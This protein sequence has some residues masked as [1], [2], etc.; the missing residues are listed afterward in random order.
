M[1]V[2]VGIEMETMEYINASYLK[3]EVALRQQE[4][5]GREEEEEE[6]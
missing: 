2:P 3:T 5:M 4:D 6:D 1:L